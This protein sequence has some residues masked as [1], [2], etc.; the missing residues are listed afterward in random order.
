MENTDA[1]GIPYDYESIMHYPWTS[2]SVNGKRTMEPIR[3]TQGKVPYIE[4][5][6]SDVELVSRMYNCPAVERKRNAAFQR[7]RKR[8]KRNIGYVN[9]DL[10]MFRYFYNEPYSTKVDYFANCRDRHFSFL[11]KKR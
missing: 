9:F 10:T 3:D 6:S 2:F 11:K 1:L 8:V 4:I 5:S 7:V